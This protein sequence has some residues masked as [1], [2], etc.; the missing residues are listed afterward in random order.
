MPETDLRQGRNP[1]RRLWPV[2]KVVVAAGVPCILAS[3]QTSLLAS[4]AVPYTS[5]SDQKV[6][7]ESRLPANLNPPRV[8]QVF[9]DP[10]FGS[11][12]VR[13]TD[14]GSA[15]Q[16]PG[17]SWT[18]N[19]SAE[20]NEW[21]K[22]DSSGSYK[23]YVISEGNV[24]VV[25]SF[26]PVTMK[27]TA[28]RGAEDGLREINGGG[29][30]SFTDSD[31]LYGSEPRTFA[32]G[33]IT[34]TR[35]K[36]KY[37]RIFDTSKCAGIGRLD[38]YTDDVSVS[39][40]DR[41]LM[42]AENG[43]QDAWDRVV[44]YD[45]AEKACRFWN[46]STGQVGG[47][48]GSR[49]DPTGTMTP[50]LPAF[51]IHN[52]RMSRDGKWVR[53]TISGGAMAFWEVDTLNVVVCSGMGTGTGNKGCFGHQVMGYS[54]S[55]NNE[56]NNDEMQTFYRKLSV[57]VLGDAMELIAPI[58]DR[59]AFGH[60]NHFTWNNVDPE[61]SAP[62]CDAQYSEGKGNSGAPHLPIRRPW[63]DEIVCIRTDGTPQ[64]WRFAHHRSN[65]TNG[66]HSIPIPQISQD[67]KFILFA[68]DWE[69]SLGTEKGNPF[70]YDV[71][72]VELK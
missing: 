17:K 63:D 48:L 16:E 8:N 11:R 58:P 24:D 51:G 7:P 42:M 23:F 56:A 70:R 72:V 9:S 50:S 66:F 6:Q 27:S 26:D 61:D 28:V 45:Q 60:D 29:S 22:A 30:W 19:S 57:P 52:A 68:S 14:A 21:S 59:G 25:R 34:F 44:V 37:S 35:N 13:V 64:V 32:F 38:G 15:G 39:S 5:R 33:K 36:A 54:H 20:Q 67:G 65:A 2:L 49:N 31:V 62:V 10:D 41:R 46:T 3:G 1:L 55:V 69:N 4:V 71:F 12:M 40:D 43:I 18:T 47:A 53:L